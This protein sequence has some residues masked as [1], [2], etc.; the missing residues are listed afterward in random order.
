VSPLIC[1][2]LM[3]HG[4]PRILFLMLA[5]TSVLAIFTVISVPRKKRM[6]V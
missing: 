4:E 1:G 2:A 6:G 5:A 3:D